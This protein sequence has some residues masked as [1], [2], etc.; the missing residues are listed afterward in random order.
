MGSGRM[1]SLDSLTY[2]RL[3]P[4]VEK[5]WAERFIL[6]QR[7]LGVSGKR[8][9]DSLALVESHVTESG[10]TAYAAFGDPQTYAK[11]DAPELTGRRAV[12][13]D[14]EW[15]FGILL[16]LSGMLLS[17]FSAQAGFSG[18]PALPVTAGLIVVL[19]IVVGSVVFM[20]RAPQALRWMFADRPVRG[21]IGWMV[22]LA[23]T[24]GALI[25]LHHPLGEIA[26]GNALTVG[27][28]LIVAGV[29]L[30]LHA[31]LG[32]RVKDDPIVGPG[33]RPVA[34]RTGLFAVMIFPVATIAMI[35]MS[36]L[37]LQIPMLL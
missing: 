13:I 33:H 22:L 21:W 7:L 36:W 27:S 14:K 26:V 16:G 9:G 31:Y 3:A 4:S 29:I 1:R 2:T 6:E 18:E 25:L 37:M 23:A 5:S 15:G 12:R 35:A 34:S 20:L 8:I 32:G 17:S 11:E 24:V 28:I 30:Q 10:E 19:V